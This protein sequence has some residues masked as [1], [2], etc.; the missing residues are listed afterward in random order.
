MQESGFT[1]IIHMYLS[2]WN[3]ATESRKTP[4]VLASGGEEFNTGPETRLD[5]S[6]FLCNKILLKYKT[7]R[8]NFWHRH[9]KG[10]ER[11]PPL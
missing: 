3:V 8:E 5:C 9:Y 11:V 6:E 2:Y 7:D 4:E 1:E 10:A